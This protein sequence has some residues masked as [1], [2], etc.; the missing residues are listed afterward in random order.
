MNNVTWFLFFVV[1]ALVLLVFWLLHKGSGCSSISN[2]LSCKDPKF[3]DTCADGYGR[4]EGQCV[5]ASKLTCPNGLHN[6][7]FCKPGWSGVLC[8]QKVVETDK[9]FE[10]SCGTPEQGSCNPTTGL[11]EC[12]SPW[13]GENCSQQFETQI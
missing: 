13:T 9:C 1:L 6:E 11:C 2:C 5:E 3:C 12:K 8:D 7:C 10:V 4:N